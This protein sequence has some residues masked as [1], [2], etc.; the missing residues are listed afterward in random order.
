V[1]MMPSRPPKTA[2][3]MYW[4]ASVLCASSADVIS[5]AMRES[6]VSRPLKALCAILSR[7]V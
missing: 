1:V 4:P 7:A 3:L 2:A 6:S 5:W